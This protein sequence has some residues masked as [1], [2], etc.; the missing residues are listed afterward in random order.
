[1]KIIPTDELN[2][3]LESMKPEQLDSYLRENRESLA[4][5]PKAGFHP[6]LRH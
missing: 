5:D 6:H 3:R 4:D 1:M 2:D